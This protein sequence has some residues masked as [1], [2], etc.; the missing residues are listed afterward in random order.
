MRRFLLRSSILWMKLDVGG[1]LGAV[2]FFFWSLEVLELHIF[3]HRE[4]GC[5]ENDIITL[6]RKSVDWQIIRSNLHV[7]FIAV[8]LLISFKELLKN[9]IWL[10]YYFLKNVSDL[11]WFVIATLKTGPHKKYFHIEVLQSIFSWFHNIMKPEL[12]HAWKFEFIVNFSSSGFP[13]FLFLIG[14]D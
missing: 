13:F 14:W 12:Q 5:L 6:F 4:F 3:L 1:L 10:N 11:F 9:D 7:E 8:T 2:A